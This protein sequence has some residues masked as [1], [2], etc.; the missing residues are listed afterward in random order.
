[1]KNRMILG[2]MMVLGLVLS[3]CQPKVIEVVKEVPVESVVVKEVEVEKIVKVEKIVE[4]EVTPEPVTLRFMFPEG[5]GRGPGFESAVAA[6]QQLNS[7]VTIEME[8][9]PYGE[10][11]GL[12]PVQFAGDSPEQALPVCQP[13]VGHAVVPGEVNLFD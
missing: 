5:A 2:V 6:Y 7:N 13:S 8:S 10:Y 4:V 3:A 9:I 12:L 1:M 11:F